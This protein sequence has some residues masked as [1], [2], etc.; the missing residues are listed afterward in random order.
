[1]E[2]PEH[3]ILMGRLPVAVDL[4]TWAEW[5]GVSD[6]RRVGFDRIG[7]VEVSTVFLGINMNWRCNGDPVL[8]ETMIFRGPLDQDTWRY[9]TYDQAERGHQEAVTQAKIAAAQIK[10]IKDA[11]G[12]T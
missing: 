7:D 12:A 2:W 6:N 9:A 3:Y 8:F 5:F 11:A 1:M 10:S 4:L